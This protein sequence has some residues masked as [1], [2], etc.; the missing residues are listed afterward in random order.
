MKYVA[1]GL[2]VLLATAFLALALLMVG[3]LQP[4]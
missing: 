3:G 4:T 2:L 1:Y